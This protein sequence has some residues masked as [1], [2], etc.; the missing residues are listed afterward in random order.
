MEKHFI[1]PKTSEIL[2]VSLI[3]PILATMR[4]ALFLPKLLSGFSLTVLDILPFSPPTVLDIPA[5]LK[6]WQKH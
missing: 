4:N 3:F 6:S 1:E 5:L 2:P